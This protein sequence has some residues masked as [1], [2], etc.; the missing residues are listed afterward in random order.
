MWEEGFQIHAAEVAKLG[1]AARMTDHRSQVPSW[2]SL[3]P[4]TQGWILL[5]IS[6]CLLYDTVPCW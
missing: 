4:P 1:E 6:G 2:V 3:W 5:K